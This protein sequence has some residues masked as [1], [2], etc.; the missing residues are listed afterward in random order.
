MPRTYVPK[1]QVWVVC[2]LCGRATKGR[3]G[4]LFCDTKHRT[5]YHSSKRWQAAK[6]ARAKAQE[7]SG[8]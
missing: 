2:W 6:R 1:E 7:E 8:R 3:A 4:R 5:R